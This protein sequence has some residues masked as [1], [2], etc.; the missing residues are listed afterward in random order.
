MKR[1]ILCCALA[2]CCSLMIESAQAQLFDRGGGLLYDDVLNVT[3]LQDANYSK[4]SGYDTDG[5][6]YWHEAKDWAANL[7]YR[8]SVR[9]VDYSDW[10]LPQILP[11]NGVNFNYMSSD[12]GSTDWGYNITSPN[13]ELA[14]MYYVNLG[15][16]GY[17]DANGTMRS[18][19]GIFGDGSDDGHDGNNGYYDQNDVG[20]VKNLQASWYWTGTE[21]APDAIDDAWTLMFGEGSQ[22]AIHKLS[23]YTHAW[24]L[25]D[26]DVAAMQPVPLSGAVWLFGSVLMGFLYSG[27]SKFGKLQSI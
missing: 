24:A 13:S 4:T 10:R 23:Y 5:W 2:A 11:V 18:D 14:F 3:W 8:D 25:R 21:F 9:N 7:V 17:R 15:L 27:R 16:K 12:D 20:L 6:M 26:G 22:M 19:W 1:R